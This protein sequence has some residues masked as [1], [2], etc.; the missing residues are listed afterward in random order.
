MTLSGIV[1][2]NNMVRYMSK[3]G[4]KLT[5]LAPQL[6]MNSTFIGKIR[7]FLGYQV[8]IKDGEESMQEE[9]EE[10]TLEN[11][12]FTYTQGVERFCMTSI[13]RSGKGRRS[14]LSDIMVEKALHRTRFAVDDYKLKY[15]IDT[16][17]TTEFEA[18]GVN[19]S[20]G[21][22]QKVAIARSLYRNKAVMIMDEPSSAL[23]PMAEYQL[24]Q[25]IHQIAEDKT[26]L[27]ISHRLSTTRDADCIYMM[28]NGRIIEHG[29]HEELL[30]S[31][32][33]YSKMWNVQAG[34]YI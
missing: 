34:R 8:K 12:S 21:E 32:G 22:G 11:V 23:D 18:Q 25:A 15:Q 29:T 1:I 26:V 5:E 16:P 31:V 9:F 19:L 4:N 6:E 30:N 2:L 3:R 10:L 20:G 28:E 27:F 33:K 7:S 14:Q 24:N 13:C 17:L